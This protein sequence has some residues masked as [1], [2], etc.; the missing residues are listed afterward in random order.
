MFGS[1]TGY[2]DEELDEW[3]EDP[4]VTPDK[5]KVGDY[6]ERRMFFTSPNRPAHKW[7]LKCERDEHGRWYLE[8]GGE[9]ESIRKHK[10]PRT[11][12]NVMGMTHR[13]KYGGRVVWNITFVEGTEVFNENPTRPPSDSLMSNNEV[14]R[15]EGRLR[16]TFCG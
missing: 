11:Y 5:L 8:V 2:Y 1:Y 10:V 15:Y 12:T 9:I 16:R 6:Y 7:G 3:V 13:P 4:W 14:L